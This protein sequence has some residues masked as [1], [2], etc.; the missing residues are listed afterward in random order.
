[1]QILAESSSAL[2]IA[3]VG[4]LSGAAAVDEPLILVF[5]FEGDRARRVSGH[6]TP[7]E[8]LSAAGR[9]DAPPADR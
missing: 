5:A 7:G 9:I 8:A 3:A 2:V 6:A 4:H 1:M